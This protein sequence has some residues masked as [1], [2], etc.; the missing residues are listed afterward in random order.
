MFLRNSSQAMQYYNTLQQIQHRL[1]LHV[2]FLKK[3]VPNKCN[4]HY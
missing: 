2:A 4:Q 1:V 3:Y